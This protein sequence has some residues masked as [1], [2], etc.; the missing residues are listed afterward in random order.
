MDLRMLSFQKSKGMA[1]VQFISPDRNTF[2][3]IS[4]PE[5]IKNQLVQVKETSEAGNVN[6]LFVFNLSDKFV[7]FMDGDILTGAKQNRVLNTSVLLAPNSKVNLSVSCVEQ[8]RWS[9]HSPEFHSS[10]YI[11]PAMLRAK[12][13]ESFKRNID[14]NNTAEANQMGV[15]DDV[16]EYAERMKV[17]SPTEDLHD[18]FESQKKAFEEVN[19]SFTADENA[20]G[21]AIF[22]EKRLLCADLFNRTNILNEYFPK[23]VRSAAMEIA[24]LKDKENPLEEAEAFYKT[25]T[26]F[27]SIG[28]MVSSVNKGM[29]VGEEKRFS[30]NKITG[31]TLG[32][33]KHLI[34][35]TALNLEP[36]KEKSIDNRRN[37]VH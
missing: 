20:N 11:V 12:K 24:Y 6:K 1:V 16:R 2:D 4:G 36:G 10:D 19:I 21:A 26:L 34:H 27:D 37:R 8:G 5:A 28:S 22:H 17:S 3:Y 7:F 14:I 9:H 29:G 33:D 18:V 30:D 31:F 15:W 35:L 23:L 13:A 32:Y 25:L